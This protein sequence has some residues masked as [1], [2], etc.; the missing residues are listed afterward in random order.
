MGDRDA[1]MDALSDA[2]QVDDSYEEA[3]FNIALLEKEPNPRRAVTML[4]KAV[5]LDANYLEAHQQLCEFS[6]AIYH[7][8]G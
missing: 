5:E 2:I 7:L 4:E 3:Y 6:R 8:R 1:A